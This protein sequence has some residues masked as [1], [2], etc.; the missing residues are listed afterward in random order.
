MATDFTIPMTDTSAAM[1]PD[2]VRK[3]FTIKNVTDSSETV[4]V[5]VIE[6]ADHTFTISN[7]NGWTPGAAYKL[8]LQEKALYFTGFDPTIRVYDFTVYR[9][10]KNLFHFSSK[11]SQ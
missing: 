2:Q 11:K 10:C 1:T 6:G 9:D 3:S 5:D 7:P 4:T 8:E